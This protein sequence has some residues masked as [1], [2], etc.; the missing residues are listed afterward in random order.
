MSSQPINALRTHCQPSC[1]EMLVLES[2]PRDDELGNRRLGQVLAL[3]GLQHPNGWGIHLEHRKLRTTPNSVPRRQFVTGPE[4]Q[5]RQKS[6][7][8]DEILPEVCSRLSSAK[9]AARMQEQVKEL[10]MGETQIRTVPHDDERRS[11]MQNLM[12]PVILL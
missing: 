2:I 1:L 7:K 8:L 4:V 11:T 3:V 12:D 9:V 5:A 10:V 6:C